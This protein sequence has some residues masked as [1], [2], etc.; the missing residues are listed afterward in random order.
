MVYVP[1]REAL[2]DALANLPVH[3]RERLA[4]STVKL[5]D[6]LD[7]LVRRGEWPTRGS[8]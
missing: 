2:W 1:S 6:Y 7:R 4:G 5:L 3:E 8:R